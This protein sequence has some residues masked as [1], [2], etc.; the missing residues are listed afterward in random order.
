MNG[1][2]AR[3]VRSSLAD[4]RSVPIER[5]RGRYCC[6]FLIPLPNY[7]LNRYDAN[8]LTSN[9]FMTTRSDLLKGLGHPSLLAM[10]AI[11]DHLLGIVPPGRGGPLHARRSVAGVPGSLN[12]LTQ[13][14]WAYSK[15]FFSI[16]SV[17]H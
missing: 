4:L 2:I 3:N 9:S 14:G 5:Y 13:L 17:K 11:R 6:R 15:C 10:I 1:E 12:T 8:G 7:A 16:A